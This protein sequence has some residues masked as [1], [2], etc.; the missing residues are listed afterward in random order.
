M[1]E[2]IVVND[3]TI[4]TCPNDGLGK[5]SHIDFSSSTFFASRSRGLTGAAPYNAASGSLN[6]FFT[7]LP[8]NGD[9]AAPGA[10]SNG[11]RASAAPN[12]DGEA[13]FAAGAANGLAAFAGAAAN[14]LAAF[15]GAAAPPPA[16]PAP[17]PSNGLFVFFG[18]SA[19]PNVDG[20]GFGFHFFC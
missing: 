2:I 1:R 14:G 11:D 15:A 18:N 16:A 20:K 19:S 5:D 17:G 13:F 3:N 8:P 10:G 4:T 6:G 7:L 9:F 12:G